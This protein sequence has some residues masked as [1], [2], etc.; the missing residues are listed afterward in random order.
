[1]TGL[2]FAAAAF[3]VFRLFRHAGPGVVATVIFL[4]LSSLVVTIAFLLD[5]PRL[6]RHPKINEAA[7]QLQKRN[8]LVSTSFSADRAFRVH[9][10]EEKGPHYFLELEDGTVLH[11]SGEYLNDYEPNNGFPRHFPCTRFTVR[12]HAELGHVV[13]ILCGGLVIEPELE[14]PPYTARDYACGFVPRDGEILS[15]LTFEQLCQ[16]RV[17]VRYRLH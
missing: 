9:E 10:F 1:M 8:L 3:A 4:Y 7:G 12:R 5:Y 6:P 16:Q 2:A 11:L 13:D 14:A 17:G 15:K